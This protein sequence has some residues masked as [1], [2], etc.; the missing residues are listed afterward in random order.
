MEKNDTPLRI[1]LKWMNATF[2]AAVE[3][4]PVHLNRIFNVV[5]PYFAGTSSNFFS[6][7]TN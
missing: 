1:K 7:T 5:F 4:Q 2:F 3:G 6:Q